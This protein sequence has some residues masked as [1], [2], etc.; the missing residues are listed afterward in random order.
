MPPS[1]R[2][3]GVSRG[4]LG[5]CLGESQHSQ[6]NKQKPRGSDDPRGFCLALWVSRR[7]CGSV[8]D[9]EPR[10]LVTVMRVDDRRDPVVGEIR[11]GRD[12][13]LDRG[14]DH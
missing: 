14:L 7:C 6:L 2:G 10:G 4:M 9:V 3:L 11:V 5:K 12:I 13:D 8:E 1:V